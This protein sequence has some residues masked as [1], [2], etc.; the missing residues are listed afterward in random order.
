MDNYT[1]L[2]NSFVTNKK[3]KLTHP[4]GLSPSNK[5]TL[6]FLQHPRRRPSTHTHSLAG[7]HSLSGTCE[8]R[9]QFQETHHTL[10]RNRSLS[11]T[12]ENRQPFQETRL[13]CKFENQ[14][15][16]QFKIT[17]K[18]DNAVLKKT[19]YNYKNQN[20]FQNLICWSMGFYVF[21]I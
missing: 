5:L 10:A 14:L 15:Q 19:T 17:S 4:L 8:N 9:Q 18:I 20:Y 6:T 12:C 16:N 13:T 1:L 2:C 21:K 7:N 11:V 3:G